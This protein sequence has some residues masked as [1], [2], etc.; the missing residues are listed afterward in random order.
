MI[1]VTKFFS[2]VKYCSMAGLV[3]AQVLGENRYERRHSGIA[4]ET[5]ERRATGGLDEHEDDDAER[6]QCDDAVDQASD[7]VREHA[8]PR[9]CLR[10]S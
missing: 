8:S 7:D 5:V 2:H 10:V 4:L 3:Q 1:G 6:K 9:A